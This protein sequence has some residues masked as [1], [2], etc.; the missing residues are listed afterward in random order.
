MN[1]ECSW[2]F[3]PDSAVCIGLVECNPSLL[4][5]VLIKW[6]ELQ[7]PHFSLVRPVGVAEIQEMRRQE[8]LNTEKPIT[9]QHS[10]A[11]IFIHLSNL[12]CKPPVSNKLMVIGQK[13]VKRLNKEYKYPIKT[14]LYSRQTCPNRLSN[15][16]LSLKR[17]K[18]WS[19]FWNLPVSAHLEGSAQL[20]HGVM[21]ILVAA[22]VIPLHTRIVLVD[23]ARLGRCP[24]SP[25]LFHVCPSWSVHSVEENDHSERSVSIF[26]QD[27]GQECINLQYMMDRKYPTILQGICYLDDIAYLLFNHLYFTVFHFSTFYMIDIISFF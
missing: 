19:P 12:Y 6:E 4:G 10:W 5:M 16:W 14:Y 22:F 13:E 25:S 18:I 20:P 15:F 9:H 3:A 17:H 27:L 26:S 1:S 8:S 7:T 2:F 11:S 21:N 23:V 24:F